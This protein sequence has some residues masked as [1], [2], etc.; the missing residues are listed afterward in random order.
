MKLWNALL[1]LLYPPRCAFCHR[2]VASSAVTICE[3][4]RKNLPYTENRAQQKMNF[5][6][7]CVSPLYYENDVRQSLLRYKFHGATGYASVYA[8]LVADCIRTQLDKEFD[9]ITWVPLS[10]KRLRRRGY[11]QARLLAEAVAEALGTA[12]VGTLKKVQHTAAQ[13]QTGSAEKRRANI[14]GAYRVPAPAQIADKRILLI[15]DIVTTG[16]TLSE[17]ARTLGLAGAEQVV[18][19]TV[20]R[21]R[22]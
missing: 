19:A 16:S 10:R 15:D 22:D 2:L 9:L 6:A 18:C 14:S 8:P 7:A 20:A 3:A 4:C 5:V 12:A 13:S 11:D 21:R 17:C 1:D